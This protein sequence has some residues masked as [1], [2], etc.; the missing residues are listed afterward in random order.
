MDGHRDAKR[1]QQRI[2]VFTSSTVTART[3]CANEHD[4]LA[5]WSWPP[6]R[7]VLPLV[8]LLLPPAQA[9]LRGRTCGIEVEVLNTTR[10]GGHKFKVEVRRLGWEGGKRRQRCLLLPPSHLTALLLPLA[11]GQAIT[12]RWERDDGGNAAAA[13]R[14]AA[15]RRL[16]KQGQLEQ[17]ELEMSRAAKRLYRERCA[18]SGAA[19]LALERQDTPARPAPGSSLSYPGYCDKTQTGEGNCDVSNKGSLAMKPLEGMQVRRSFMSLPPLH[20]STP[21]PLHPYAPTPLHPSTMTF[22]T[23]NP[24]CVSRRRLVL[25]NAGRVRVATTLPSRRSILIA[26]GTT[27]AT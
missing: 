21:T 11:T 13:A 14:T 5:R 22:P 6:E 26:R 27:A 10:S 25:T 24:L 18:V 23:I 8:Q 19:G 4:C 9:Q 2:S 3:P 20:P 16:I 7:A 17:R 1:A 12:I 15:C